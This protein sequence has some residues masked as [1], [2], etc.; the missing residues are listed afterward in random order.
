MDRLLSDRATA[1]I[2]SKINDILRVYI[3]DDWQSEPY[4][5]HQNYA[6][7]H[8]AIIKSKTNIILSRTGAPASTWLL[9][10]QY[11]CYLFNHM[12]IRSLDWKTPLQLLTGETTDISI[13]HR[14]R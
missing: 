14:N 13:L 4:H 7:R 5:Q 2:R 10:I 3:I 6:E 9:C 1:E 12:A 11:V 8:Y